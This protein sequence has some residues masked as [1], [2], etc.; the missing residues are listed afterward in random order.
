MSLHPLRTLIIGSALALAVVPA[1]GGWSGDQAP[2]L[3]AALKH[4]EDG[5]FAR[6]AEGFDAWLAQQADPTDPQVVDVLLK[7]V[8]C[9]E[10][11]SEY[12]EALADLRGALRNGAL[13]PLQAARVEEALGDL[14]FGLPWGA[15]LVD[16]EPSYDPDL[17]EGEWVSR[18]AHNCLD[19][20]MHLD[21][22]KL[23]LDGQLRTDRG[24][25]VVQ[26]ALDLDLRL[27][28]TLQT[29][30]CY[31]DPPDRPLHPAADLPAGGT[32]DPRWP[33]RHKVMFLY[34]EVEALDRNRPYSDLST[35]ARARYEAALALELNGAATEPPDLPDGVFD[36]VLPLPTWDAA[37]GLDALDRLI[38]DYPADTQTDLHRFTHASFLDSRGEFAAAEQEAEVFLA[39]FPESAW[40]GDAR[41]LLQSIR[42]PRLSVTTVTMV[43]PGG[44]VE[45]PVNARNLDSVRFTAHRVDLQA[46]LGN[47]ARLRNPDVSFDDFRRNF[48][49][50]VGV[51]KHYLEK[52]ASW[53]LD[54]PHSGD[55]AY[56]EVSTT[57]PL[58]DVGSYVVE[59]TGGKHAAAFLVIVSDVTVI[60]RQD[61]ASALIFVADALTGEPLD[62]FPLI[63][64][65]TYWDYSGRGRYRTELLAAY[66]DDQGTF[67]YALT[68]GDVSSNSVGVLAIEGDRMA[69][70]PQ[71]W[72]GSYG[73]YGVD[74]Q[75]KVFSYTDRPV[76]RPG[77]TVHFK[78]LMRVQRGGQ[79]E[80]LPGRTV[81]V[82][83]TDPQGEELHVE[84]LTTSEYGTLHGELTLGEE[85]PLGVHTFTLEF[86][87][88][89]TWIP[90]SGGSQFRVEEYRKPE[91]E[92]TVAASTA[93]T[94][95]GV[96]VP[97]DITATYYFGAP[98]SDARVTYRVFRAPYSHHFHRPG[99]YDWLYGAGYG[100][101][102]EQPYAPGQELVEEG[103]LTTDADGRAQ[104]LLAPPADEDLDFAYDV[105]VEVMD[106]ARRTIHG[107][108][109]VTVTRQPFFAAVD[110]DRGFFAPGD[111]VELEV[112]AETAGRAPVAAE[113]TLRF[114]R[115][116]VDEDTAEEVLTLLSEAPLTLAEDGRG[117][118][119]FVPDESGAYR[120]EFVAPT[121]EDG[122][123]TAT[124]ELWVYDDQFPGRRVRFA[125]LEL[126]T[127][128]RTY[129]EGETVRL[130]VQ[131]PFVDPTVLLSFDGASELI[132]H[133]VLRV[134]GRSAVVE[135]ELGSAHVP[136]F[137]AR[138]AM[139][140]D[141]QVFYCN[142]EI[143]VPPHEQ[144]LQVSVEG[145][146][147]EYRPGQ[148]GEVTITV[149]DADG[150]PVQG[151]FSLAA[152]D[153]ALY[154]IQADT[155]GDIRQYFHGDRRYSSYSLSHSRSFSPWPLT[156]D[157]N[158]W[159]DHD[160]T[161]IP[162]LGH[163]GGWYDGLSSLGYVDDFSSDA[164]VDGRMQLST[165]AYRAPAK[166]PAKAMAGD[167]ITFE[168]MN[169]AG[170]VPMTPMSGEMAPP[171]QVA[172][173]ARPQVRSEFRDTAHWEPVVITDSDGRATVEITWP[174]TLTTWDVVVRGIDADSRVGGG[175]VAAVTSRDLLVR[176][177]GPR[178]LVERDS[179]VLSA[180]VDNRGDA[181]V[182]AVVTLD[183]PADLVRVVGDPAATVE[184]PAGGQ[185]R[186]DFAI[187]VLR[188]GDASFT[189]SVVAGEDSDAV[190]Q[191]FPVLTWGTVKTVAETAVLRDGGRADMDLAVP[192]DH[193]DG[194]AVLTVHLSPSLASVMVDALPYL[195]DYPYGCVEQTMSRFLPA[196]ITSHTLRELGV[197]LADL[198][199]AR[200]GALGE[201][202]ADLAASGTS[203][204][205]DDRELDRAVRKG[206]ARLLA[207]QHADGGW[208]WWKG[209]SSDP[210]M[211]AYVVSGMQTARDAGHAVDPGSL[212]RGYGYLNRQFEATA[213]DG[214]GAA[215]WSHRRVY[216]AYVLSQRGKLKPGDLDTEF[217]ARADLSNYGKALLALAL[218][219]AGDAERAALVVENLRDLARVDESSGT[220]SFDF[221]DGGPWWSWY[222]DRV[223]TNAWAL[224]AFLA[225]APDDKLADPLARWLVNN[226]RG[227]RWH[228]TKDTATA[229]LA[230]SEYARARDELDADY[231][232]TV[233][234]DGAEVF[235]ARVTRDNLFTL[236]TQIVLRGDAVAAGDHDLEIVTSGKGTLYASAY[237]TYFTTEKDI[238]ASGH[239]LAVGRHYSLL[240]P[241]AEPDVVRRGTI[242][243]LG[244]ERTPLRRGARV[245]AGDLVEVR[246]EV[247]SPNTYEYLVFEDYK[248]AGFESEDL[249][250]GYMYDNGTFFNRELRDDKVVFFLDRLRQGEQ[251]LTYRLRAE[252]PGTF[253]VLPHSGHA[254]YAPRVA[255][256]S[257]SFQLKVVDRP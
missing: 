66:T 120:A 217:D 174:D 27:A 14:S 135:V 124:R 91:F 105:Q 197:D 31:G 176:L 214:E 3:A 236:P 233:R 140:H 43:P 231:G 167:K 184:V 241:T 154:Y 26:R 186:L 98:V 238:E 95:P 117:F 62:D 152:V 142:R 4:H 134:T 36:E 204:V 210:Y 92:V 32:Y 232:L 205:L 24:D 30:N 230:L 37:D 13:P 222:H 45:L 16:G 76:Y 165:M 42:V 25:E 46:V 225:I 111:R 121:G 143:F 72:V 156:R 155:A 106:L 67:R 130:M 133:Q 74:E 119:E 161:G 17:Y 110:A 240:T 96:E 58:P 112:R 52:V 126:I 77:Q 97:V 41:N 85:P 150:R 252:T 179:L 201:H 54:V 164:P 49:G 177:L 224:R 69:V 206:L 9:Q 257:D 88:E 57:L 2:D 44:G 129:R 191:T 138:A 8:Q 34:A 38:A 226:R 187:E 190:R 131:S 145:D 208:G 127:E 203:P 102:H 109:Q 7:K 239:E 247:Q 220:A 229:I 218:H 122:G 1:P 223:E 65:E 175:N 33:T 178:F 101:I 80:N 21:R 56:H 136:N 18:E 79:Y 89:D 139:A 255:A 141:Y 159:R 193:R 181:A 228:S 39:A 151:E 237:L 68:G 99:P 40:A 162:Y 169:I 171:P 81:R 73:Y 253:H 168:E 64:K 160:A 115:V 90:L 35:A 50:I 5:N 244:Y 200:P 75:Y 235:E 132:E 221:D 242:D 87:D 148:T 107:A 29:S 216:V 209:G 12:D 113:G 60:V 23:I 211:S 100:V 128:K 116:E 183:A 248:P 256:I 123:V 103:E 48:G 170:M 166:A 15:Y 250:S 195:I 10:V 61:E 108:G 188:A 157:R 125:N 118:F 192:Q 94:R 194:S 51:R 251:I 227:N 172:A 153:E 243:T 198:E 86:P 202:A 212:A 20:F 84:E 93:E 245:A 185:I 137:F 163:R 158:R 246:L 219:N 6:A 146:R 173:G 254:M 19:G 234:L 47:G 147:D 83:V 22:A 70:T 55:H 71:M 11:L 182:G 149:Q 28:R 213:P 144:L 189:A 207:F 104:V 63:V 114:H 249:K 78:H 180:V 199:G 82:R 53:Q 215:W 59:A 196:A